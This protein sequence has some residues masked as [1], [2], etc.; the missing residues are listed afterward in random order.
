MTSLFSRSRA[1]RQPFMR[2]RTI[3]GCGGRQIKLRRLWSRV[4]GTKR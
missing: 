1:G 3:S 2:F 4:H